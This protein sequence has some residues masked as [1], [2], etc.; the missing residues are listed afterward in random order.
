MY[1]K[2]FSGLHICF[3][4]IILACLERISLS[5]TCCF[6]GCYA[7]NF[8]LLFVF[9]SLN[10]KI[11]RRREQ[12]HPPKVTTVSKMDIFMIY[13]ADLIGRGHH[14]K[15][16]N[17]FFCNVMLQN[18]ELCNI[19]MKTC[20]PVHFCAFAANIVILNSVPW[21]EWHVEWLLFDVYSFSAMCFPVSKLKG[22]FSSSKVIL[23]PA[24]RIFRRQLCATMLWDHISHCLAFW[25]LSLNSPLGN[26]EL[27]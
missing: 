2:L 14:L 13:V 6:F 15:E 17:Y 10:L 18:V 4:G 26:P 21:M 20:P 27:I 23:K 3:S 12:F 24:Y 5:C 25:I 8:Y 22:V 1:G 19:I 16:S 9:P 7:I 11:S